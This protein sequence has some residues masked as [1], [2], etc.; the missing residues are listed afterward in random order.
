MQQLEQGYGIHGW[1]RIKRCAWRMETISEEAPRR[2]GAPKFWDKHGLEATQDFYK[3]SRRTL[4]RWRHL[5]KTSGHTPVNLTKQSCAPTRRRVRLW[6]AAVLA[7]LRELR[8][9]HLS[10]GAEKLQ[11][12]PGGL[13]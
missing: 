11:I 4:F 2:L 6:P 10:L 8:Q 1:V 3:M 9:N 7:R 13:V 12:F 5:Y